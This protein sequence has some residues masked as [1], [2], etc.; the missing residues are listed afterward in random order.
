MFYLMML[1]KVIFKCVIDPIYQS[2]KQPSIV[3]TVMDEVM[4]TEKFPSL[5]KKHGNSITKD[6]QC[7]PTFHKWIIFLNTPH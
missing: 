7:S 3:E 4:G 6:R 1:C 2:P 5:T